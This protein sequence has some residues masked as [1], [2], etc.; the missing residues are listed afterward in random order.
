MKCQFRM[1]KGPNLDRT[2]FI[3]SF[4]MER[5]AKSLQG[6]GKRGGQGGLGVSR[7]GSGQGRRMRRL[8]GVSISQI[9]DLFIIFFPS[10]QAPEPPGAPQEAAGGGAEAEIQR[11]G[12]NLRA[13]GEN[14]PDFPIS[15]LPD[16]H[17][18]KK[19]NSQD[20][21][22]PFSGPKGWLRGKVEDKNTP[23][24][25]IWW[26]KAPTKH[27]F[28]GMKLQLNRNLMEFTFH[29]LFPL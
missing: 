21:K 3:P 9:Y 25:Q 11:G 15:S 26:G 27:E 12:E 17:C 14:S 2:G 18:T 22:I 20:T 28:N 13:E 16:F 29:T 4:W 1:G 6:A 5:T 24:T 7:R 19:N 10:E 8:Y 23:S